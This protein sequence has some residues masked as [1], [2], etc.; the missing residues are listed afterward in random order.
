MLQNDKIDLKIEKDSIKMNAVQLTTY[1]SSKGL[2]YEYVYMPSLK[3][4]KWESCSRPII[5]PPVPLSKEDERDEAA[6]KTYKLADKINKM[7]VGM[8][9]AKHTLRLSYVGT[10]GQIY[11]NV[12]KMFP[13]EDK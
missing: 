12:I 3:S 8:T 11:S 13:L 6:W 1:Q 10:S 7:Y 5:K 9:R 4:S 2:E